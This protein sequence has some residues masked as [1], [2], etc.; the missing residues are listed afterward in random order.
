MADKHQE[1]LM[2][3]RSMMERSSRFISLSGLSGVFA[4][5]S[6]LVGGTYVYLR[7]KNLGIDYLTS[8]NSFY[9]KDL[10]LEFFLVALIVLFFALTF[11]IYFTLQKSKK[12]NHPIWTSTTKNLVINLAIPLCVGFVFC[13]SLLIHNLFVFIAPVTLLFYG[14]ALINAE[15]YTFSDIKYL[16]Y[17]ELILGM[18]SLFFI[19]KGLLF[20]IVGFGVLHILYGIILFK[21]Y[22]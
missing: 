21:K 5:L 9:D 20:W 12:N 1:D 11:G 17:L 6:A 3:I 19:G 2:H 15:K 8:E 22:K 14:L 7:L 10:V 18:L 13:L 4:G 16:G